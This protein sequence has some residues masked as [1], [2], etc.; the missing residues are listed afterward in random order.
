MPANQLFKTPIYFMYLHSDFIVSLGAQVKLNASKTIPKGEAIEGTVHSRMMLV[1][2]T[3][4]Y[5]SPNAVS[6]LK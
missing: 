2:K 3:K 1:F 5:C 4:A 6:D